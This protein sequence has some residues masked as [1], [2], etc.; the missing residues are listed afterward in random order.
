MAQII[1]YFLCMFIINVI[2]V[3]II[4]III[5]VLR[6]KCNILL[7]NYEPMHRVDDCTFTHRPDAESWN[8][9]VLGNLPISTSFKFQSAFY[10][11]SLHTV[12]SG[13]VSIMAFPVTDTCRQSLRGLKLIVKT[14]ND[15]KMCFIFLRLVL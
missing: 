6:H 15:W 1:L 12:S 4:I 13:P 11:L 5:I 10:C 3:V 7:N 2:T 8:L 9:H 14:L